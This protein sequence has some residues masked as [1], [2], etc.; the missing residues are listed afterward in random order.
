LII[1]PIGTA[2]WYFHARREAEAARARFAAEPEV[3]WEYYP[4]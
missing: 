4:M 2:L 1:A 3:I